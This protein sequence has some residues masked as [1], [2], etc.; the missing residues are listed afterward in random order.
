M[1][2]Q[3]I[4]KKLERIEKLLLTQKS[5]LNFEEAADYTGLSKSYLYKLS[6]GG[7]IPCYKPNGKTLWFNRIEID[8]WLLRNR[9]ATL[10]EIDLAAE[11][12]VNIYK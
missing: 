12:F 8:Q 4:E 7:G 3:I 6:S 2:L 1:D 10:E 9:K 11:S 5:V